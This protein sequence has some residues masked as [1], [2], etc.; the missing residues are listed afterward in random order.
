VACT[1]FIS[2]LFHALAVLFWA[3]FTATAGLGFFGWLAVA[4]G[5]AMLAY[6]HRIVARGMER[7]DRAFFTVN[8]YLGFAYLLLIVLDRMAA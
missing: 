4:V 8:G 2:R 5:A 1:L 6:E 7:I 3:F